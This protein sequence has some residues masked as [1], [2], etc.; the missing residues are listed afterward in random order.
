MLTS[1][2]LRNKSQR[3]EGDKGDEMRGTYVSEV[4][5]CSLTIVRE[6]GITS[7]TTVPLT[8]RVYL[9]IVLHCTQN[10]S[11]NYRAR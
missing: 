10:I 3:V 9:L 5:P 4:I 6:Q 11:L 8:P 7:E 2:A 1:G